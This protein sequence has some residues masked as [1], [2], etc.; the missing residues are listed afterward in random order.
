MESSSVFATRRSTLAFA[1]IDSLLR[2]VVGKIDGTTMGEEEDE[3]YNSV[4]ELW[5]R[6]LVTK[7]GQQSAWYLRY[8]FTNFNSYTHSLL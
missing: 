6:Q 8:S 2:A 7:K 5:K 1:D 3:E 4:E